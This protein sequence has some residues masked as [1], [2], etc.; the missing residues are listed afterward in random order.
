MEKLI[1][2][3]KTEI[4]LEG[5]TTTNMFMTVVEGTQGVKDTLDK[6]SGD[7]LSS[8]EIK[9]DGGLTCAVWEN[10]NLVSVTSTKIEKTDNWLLTVT[11]KET[12]ALTQ[13]IEALEAGQ[14]VQNNAIA[15][16][17]EMVYV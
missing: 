1:L 6:L 9:N 12:D 16:M 5:G 15:D 17:S 10:K 8:C 14:E 11:L 3:D 2:K 4:L 13:R 7:N